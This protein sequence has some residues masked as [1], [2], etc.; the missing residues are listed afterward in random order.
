MT[1]ELND[2]FDEFKIQLAKLRAKQNEDQKK[3]G[4][5]YKS[6]D[7]VNAWVFTFN[8]PLKCKDTY[9]SSLFSMVRGHTPKKAH[10]AYWLMEQIGLAHI[11]FGEEWGESK[12]HHYQGF[13][14]FEYPVPFEHVKKHFPSLHI[15]K[16]KGLLKQN[17]A[18]VGK[19]GKVCKKT[20]PGWDEI[21][22]LNMVRHGNANATE[23]T[24]TTVSE[25]RLLLNFLEEKHQEVLFDYLKNYN[26]L[27]N[28]KKD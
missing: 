13:L 23:K 3:M 21:D 12:T 5:P 10:K 22:I 4:G 25:Y 19:D 20:R 18:Y 24:V 27:K 15:D 9:T 8:N 1:I 11:E 28:F 26:E 6:K 17:I 14:V 7:K 16:M 2:G